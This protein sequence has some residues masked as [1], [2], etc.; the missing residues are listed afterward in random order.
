MDYTLNEKQQG[1]SLF[2]FFL[3]RKVV[4]TE[5]LLRENQASETNS[6][7]TMLLKLSHQNIYL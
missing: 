7:L 1:I 2:F 6:T 3:L 4:L 5:M